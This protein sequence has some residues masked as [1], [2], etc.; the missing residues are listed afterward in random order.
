MPPKT[1]CLLLIAI[2]VLQFVGCTSPPSITPLLRISEK[3]LM[4]EAAEQAI[5][6]QRDTER[7]RQLMRS[8]KEATTRTW[9]RHRS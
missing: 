5:D 1:K 4:R 8:L 2:G 9:S 6:T 7:I 3:A